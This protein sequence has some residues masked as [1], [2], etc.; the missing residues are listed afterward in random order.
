MKASPVDASAIIALV[1]DAQTLDINNR[2]IFMKGIDYSYYYE[3][4]DE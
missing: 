1:K 3:E 2:E 4:S